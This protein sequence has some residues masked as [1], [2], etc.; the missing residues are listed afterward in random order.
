MDNIISKIILLRL[1]NKYFRPLFFIYNINPKNFGIKS[2][3][4]DIINNVIVSYDR[5]QNQIN[6][7]YN[8][9]NINISN[10]SLSL[11]I[12]QKFLAGGSESSYVEKPSKPPYPGVI[13]KIDYEK[14]WENGDYK[15]PAGIY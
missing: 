12:G 10:H 1:I 13:N 8:I 2:I 9:K 11:T 14:N 5:E 15:W 6:Y 4:I 3:S 7:S